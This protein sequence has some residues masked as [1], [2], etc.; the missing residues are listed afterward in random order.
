L[1]LLAGLVVELS[2]AGAGVLVV[3]E[4]ELRLA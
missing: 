3:S 1:W 2:M 4:P